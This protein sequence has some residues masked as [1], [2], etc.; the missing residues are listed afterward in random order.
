MPGQTK[1]VFAPDHVVFL[2][3]D[4]ADVMRRINNASGA[5]GSGG[6]VEF[7]QPNGETVYVAVNKIRC[8]EPE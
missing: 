2:T 4:A 3:D 6:F 1:I 5:A 7:T 8:V